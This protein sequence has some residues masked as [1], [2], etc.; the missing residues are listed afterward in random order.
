[1]SIR[2]KLLPFEKQSNTTYV[3]N[4]WIRD[5]RISRRARLL[6]IE[7]LS[8][9]DGW[10]ET[11]ESLVG[12]GT[13]GI[14]ALRTARN[15]LVDAG[16]LTVKH[17]RGADGRFE[18][19]YDL[20]DPFELD[21]SPAEIHRVRKSHAVESPVDNSAE[22]LDDTPSP[23]AVLP[24]GEIAR[25]REPRLKEINQSSNSAP[26][27]GAVDNSGD[28]DQ[29]IPRPNP[30]TIHHH[31]PGIDW[32]AVLRQCPP[33]THFAPDDLHA[34]GAEI[35]GRASSKVVDETA[36]VTRA[37]QNDPFEWE[38]AGYALDAARAA[39]GGNDF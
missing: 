30:S 25:L 29:F 16:Y 5:R 31:K 3:P 36:Y 26:A 15:E 21:N 17:E 24:A 22:T 10:E 7:L 39:R 14:S 6:A 18:S 20:S 23:H 38:Q 37:L 32:A 35:L 12:K 19:H 28:D 11:L 34:I 2:R 33:F 8:H 9:K 13:E 4:N 27:T 1:M